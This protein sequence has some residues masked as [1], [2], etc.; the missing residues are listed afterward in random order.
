V[1]SNGHPVDQDRTAFVRTAREHVASDGGDGAEHV[2]QIACD[3][4]FLDRVADLTAF[5][6]EAGCAT[7]V[8]AGD[9]VDARADQLGDVKPRIY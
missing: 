1:A 3:G 7:R 9:E 2:A 5:D 4:D 8:I 6:P